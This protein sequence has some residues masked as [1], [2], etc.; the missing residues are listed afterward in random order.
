MTAAA[1]GQPEI[2]QVL[3][4][5]GADKTIRDEDNELAVDHARNA[6]HEDIIKILQAE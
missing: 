5:N 1:L 4:D 3:L 2:V 6:G